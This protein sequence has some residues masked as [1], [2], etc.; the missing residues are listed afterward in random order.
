MWDL[1]HSAS[2]GL[3]ACRSLYVFSHTT[4]VGEASAH[5]LFDRVAIKCKDKGQAPR[6]FADYEVVV[7]EKNLPEGVTLTR[8]V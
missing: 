7:N 8:L 3:M 6:S 4:E 1:D 5:A 2:R